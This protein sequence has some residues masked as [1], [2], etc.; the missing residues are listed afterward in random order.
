MSIKLIPQ[1]KHD[2]LPIL[3]RSPV[4]EDRAHALNVL[5]WVKR[6]Q[7]D[8]DFALQVA[9][10][11]HDIERADEY[12]RIRRADFDSY[13]AFKQA[14]ARRSADVADMFLRSYPLPGDVRS[15]IYFLIANHE[16]GVPGDNELSVLKDADSL[17]FFEVNLPAYFQR[18]GTRE[19]LARLQWGFNRLSDNARQLLRHITYSKPEIEKMVHSIIESKTG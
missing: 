10:L 8:A 18:E 1:I 12:K 5:A 7:P 19:T 15:R 3:A 6:L 14:H 9:A 16:F 11:C 2:L 13:D 17:S 4:P